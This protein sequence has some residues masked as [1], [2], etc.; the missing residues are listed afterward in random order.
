MATFNATFS[1]SNNFTASFSENNGLSA[2]FGEVQYVQV[3]DWFTGDYEATP[4]DE[5]HRLLTAG[6]VL[7]HDIIINPIPSNYGRIT[8]NGAY[9][10]VS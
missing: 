6:K 5:E 4:S 7:A 8:W 9:L 1:E 2:G 3:G 10:T